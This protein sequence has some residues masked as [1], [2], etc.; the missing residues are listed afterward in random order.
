MRVQK[1][2]SH[3]LVDRPCPLCRASSRGSLTDRARGRAGR[4]ERAKRTRS[5]ASWRASR[6][7]GRR[8]FERVL[9]RDE[10]GT[11]EDSNRVERAER[12]LTGRA[13]RERGSVREREDSGRE[14]GMRTR[15]RSTAM[16]VQMNPRRGEQGEKREGEE[17]R[18]RKR[19]NGSLARSSFGSRSRPL[20]PELRL[21][22]VSPGP[23]PHS[24][25]HAVPLTGSVRAVQYFRESEDRKAPPYPACVRAVRAGLC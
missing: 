1:S 3:Q 20:D 17:E 4:G 10:K 25:Y 24:L 23:P 12:A 5:K 9:A 18:R 19:A 2:V 22:P 6:D 7:G 8:R 21:A 16:R 14:G 15:Q 11:T 13:R